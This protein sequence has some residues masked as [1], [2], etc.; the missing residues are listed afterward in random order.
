MNKKLLAGTA[1]VAIVGSLFLFTIAMGSYYT[2]DQ[3]ERAVITQN[4]A[5]MEET[6][7]GL[8]FKTPWV[9]S[10]HKFEVTTTRINYKN[11]KFPF[12]SFD[13]QE[14]TA[15]VSMNYHIAADK[16]REVYS[17]FGDQISVTKIEPAFQQEVG[18]AFGKVTA[19][20]IINDRSAVSET[21]VADLKAALA[22]YNVVVET[23]QIQLVE[24]N[25]HFTD[26]I[27]ALIQQ[28]VAVRTQKQLLEQEKVNADIAR[29]KAQGAADAR[30]VNATAEAKA[31]ELQSASLKASPEY[32]KLKLAEKWDGKMPGYVTAGAPTPLLN[33]NG[34]D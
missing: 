9:E 34:K 23:V 11:Y 28:E 3:Q 29:T 6:G 10:V 15:S 18:N 13:Q 5:V 24:F 4:G 25:Q 17:Q 21:M 30:L 20:Q 12:H 31:I 33:L 1:I 27:N 14:G 22:P 8:H 32:V 7:P 2:V 19:Q 16:V 26:S